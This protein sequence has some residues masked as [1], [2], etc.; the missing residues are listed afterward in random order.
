MGLLITAAGHRAP[1]QELPIEKNAEKNLQQTAK[2]R[3]AK[4]NVELKRFIASLPGNSKGEAK[5][6]VEYARNASPQ[7]SHSYMRKLKFYVDHESQEVLVKVIDPDTDKVIKILPP[8]EIQMLN[9]NNGEY[10]GFLFDR[11]V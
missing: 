11:Q 4:K 1:L 5:P 7:A 9:R 2:A 10:S 6:A 8:E 3:A